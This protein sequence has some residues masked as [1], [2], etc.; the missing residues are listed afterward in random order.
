M[1]ALN[2]NDDSYDLS[3]LAWLFSQE[4]EMNGEDYLEAGWSQLETVLEQA[5]AILDNPASQE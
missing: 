1:V 5:A 3:L 4:E 2:L